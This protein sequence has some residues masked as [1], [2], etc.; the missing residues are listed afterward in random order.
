MEELE[1]EDL[2]A[3]LRALLDAN[4]FDWARAEAEASVD[5]TWHPRW[6]ANA[7]IVA[8]EDVTVNL[9]RAELAMIATFGGEVEFKPDEGAAP[10]DDGFNTDG[11][12]DY[13]RRATVDRLRGIERFEMLDHLSALQASFQELKGRLDGQ[14]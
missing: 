5:P 4:G 14:F 12:A 6:L 7:L 8:A 2:I 13:L 11:A 9:A 10:D 3:Q 1:I